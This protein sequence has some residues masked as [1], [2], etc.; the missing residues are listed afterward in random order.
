MV[1]EIEDARSGVRPLDVFAGL[2]ELPPLAVCHGRIGHPL[3]RMQPSDQPTVKTNRALAERRPRC[4]AVQIKELPV[5]VLPHL[6]RNL[7]AHRPRIFPGASDA[8]ENRVRVGFFK[9]HEIHHRV[10]RWLRVQGFEEVFVLERGEDG[11][12]MPVGGTGILVLEI[13]HEL[14]VDIEDARAGLG[15]LEVAAQP[16]AG[17][18]DPAQHAS[19]SSKTQVSLLPPPCEELTTSEPLRIATRVSPPGMIVHFSP[20]KM[21]GRRSMCRPSNLP[22][23]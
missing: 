10:R 5:Q 18:G 1:F 9:S 7:F 20:I 4:G 2:Q 15:A 11:Q 6:A 22:S 23:T 21:Y 14:H 3:E 12:P 8:R 17:I 19:P 13:Q 16:E